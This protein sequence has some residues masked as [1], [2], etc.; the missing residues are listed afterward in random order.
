MEARHVSPRFSLVNSRFS[1]P[2]I[3]TLVQG[4]SQLLKDVDLEQYSRIL[5][6]NRTDKATSQACSIAKGRNMID[7]GSRSLKR[8]FVRGPNELVSSSLRPSPIMATLFTNPK[9]GHL[10]KGCYGRLW[11]SVAETGDQQCPVV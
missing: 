4:R 11:V 10:D 6:P 8:S 5:H 7:R 2:V 3:P 1:L 9:A